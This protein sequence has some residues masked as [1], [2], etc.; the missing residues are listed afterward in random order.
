MH[1][2]SYCK[3]V[4]C[5]WKTKKIDIMVVQSQQL[6]QAEEQKHVIFIFIC[7][8]NAECKPLKRTVKNSNNWLVQ[9]YE[10]FHR[11]F[12]NWKYVHQSLKNNF[13]VRSNFDFE[14]QIYSFAHH[15]SV[16]KAPLMNLRQL[17]SKVFK[18]STGFKKHGT[19]CF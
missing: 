14:V 8:D 13:E 7:S 4:H 15:I 18:N 9:Q 5:V 6:H 19:I 1:Q 10:L 17:E 11:V 12:R 2:S 16:F 3:H